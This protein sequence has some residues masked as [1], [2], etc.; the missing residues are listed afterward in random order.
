MV[1]VLPSFT[2]V[3]LHLGPCSDSPYSLIAATLEAIPPLSGTETTG[4][5]FTLFTGDLLAHD[6]SNQLSR[7]YTEYSEVRWQ[8][9]RVLFTV[10]KR[11]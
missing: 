8:R 2:C 1:R 6:P 11:L 5:N 3:E 7:A 4:F 10:L 9:Q